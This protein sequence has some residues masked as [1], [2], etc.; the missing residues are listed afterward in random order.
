MASMCG[1][2]FEKG[3]SRLLLMLPGVV[4]ILLGVAVLIQPQVLV[5]LV[6]STAVLLGVAMLLMAHFMYRLGAKL[7]GAGG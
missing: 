2:I 3:T 4:L 7:R 1:G 6:A 5:W